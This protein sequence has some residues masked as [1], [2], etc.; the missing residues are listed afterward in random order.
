[1][2]QVFTNAWER[3]GSAKLTPRWTAS[4]ANSPASRSIPRNAS[5]F[6][7][8]MIMTTAH[9]LSGFLG[10]S[11]R[12]DSDRGSDFGA[13]SERGGGSLRG[14]G[15]FRGAGSERGGGSFLGDSTRGGGS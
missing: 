2:R 14:G 9:G 1:M 7:I 3:S 4:P 15:S 11:E 5:R 8:L 12:G 10:P 6:L 13:G